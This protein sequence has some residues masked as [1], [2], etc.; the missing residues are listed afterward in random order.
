MASLVSYGALPPALVGALGLVFV[1]LIK[2]ASSGQNEIKMIRVE[3]LVEFSDSGI[4]GDESVEPESDFQ[5]FRV[6]DFSGDFRLNYQSAPHRS[7]PDNK[8]DKFRLHNGD[9]LVVKSSG[10][11]KQVVSG[12]VAVFRSHDSQC[13]AASNFLLRLHLKPQLNPDYIAFALGSPPIREEI[14]GLVKTMTYPNLSYKI[15]K[16]IRVPVLET[17]A[18]EAIAEFFSAFLNGEQLPVLPDQL[19]SVGNVVAKIESLVD[20]IDEARQLR[21]EIQT[22]MDSLLV[23]MA[24]RNDLSDEQKLAQ[25]WERVVLGD[26]LAQ[27]SDPVEVEPGMEYPHFGIYSFAKG[28]FKK[29]P[30]LG[31]EIKASKLYRVNE[32]QFIY[33]RLNA[34]EGAFAVI[35]KDYDK[36]HVSNEFPTFEC[37]NEKVQPEFLLAYFSTPAVWEALKRKVTGIGG[38]A[39]NR[40]IR[41]KESV[42]LSDEIWLPPIS[43]QQKIKATAEQLTAIKQDR[44]SA[45]I[46]LDALLPAI[47]DKAFKGEL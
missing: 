34:Y 6:S 15:Y 9:L 24:H 13:F 36:H 32:G 42:L 29:A 5:V 23:A 35:S 26:V 11:A 47:L 25:G 17:G 1:N 43:W 38:G 45:G 2:H 19:Q 44:E 27:I 21:R 7:I 16:N 30:L 10:S 41:L 12:R 33:G 37:V 14:A 20:R 46:E 31:D 8:K 4:W 18:Q 40:R 28:L 39:G 22:D 3:E